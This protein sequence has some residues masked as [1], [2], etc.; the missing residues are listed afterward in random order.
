MAL[1]TL[2][3]ELWL[4]S[5]SL[6]AAG[7]GYETANPQLIRHMTVPGRVCE[8]RG[9]VSRPS[10][11]CSGK[12]QVTAALPPESDKEFTGGSGRLAR[13]VIA[14]GFKLRQ[15]FRYPASKAIDRQ[16]MADCRRI[17]HHDDKMVK[18]GENPQ[19]TAIWPTL[20]NSG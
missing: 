19:P 1:S 11:D 6:R 12:W 9:S 8:F 10:G 13:I 7:L 3:V 17:L 4:N 20:N 5:R 15:P 18:S 14:A 16:T 2:F